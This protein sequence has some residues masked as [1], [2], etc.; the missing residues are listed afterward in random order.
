MNDVTRDI[1]NIKHWRGVQHG[2]LNVDLI[3]LKIWDNYNKG[4]LFNSLVLF[5][6]TFHF[7]L[8]PEVFILDYSFKMS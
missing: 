3:F 8:S 6:F 1:Q 2:S 4:I 5:L 7:N